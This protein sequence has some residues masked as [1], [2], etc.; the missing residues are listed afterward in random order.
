MVGP[1][2]LAIA[3]EGE[4]HREREMEKYHAFKMTQPDGQEESEDEQQP[5]E[6]PEKQP[7]KKAASHSKVRTQ[8]AN[9]T[10]TKEQRAGT[11]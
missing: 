10:S 7:E 5:E 3:A 6:R 9:M 11:E 1:E 4:A 2:A 8:Q